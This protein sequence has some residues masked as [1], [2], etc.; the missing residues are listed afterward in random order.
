MPVVFQASQRPAPTWLRFLLRNFVVYNPMFVFSALLALVGAFLINPPGADGGRE[1]LPQAQ[2]FGVIQ[3]YECA[4]L[5]AAWLLR[6]RVPQADVHPFAPETRDVRFL[7]IVLAPFLLDV[8]FTTSSL[9]LSLLTDFGPSRAFVFG[10]ALAGFAC[11]KLHLALRLVGIR[12]GV[13][14][15][16]VFVLGPAAV[17]ATPLVGGALA[18]EGHVDWVGPVLGAVAAALVVAYGAVAGAEGSAWVMRRLAPLALVAALVH[19]C[20]A[21]YTYDGELQLVLGP[22]LIAL[23]FALPRLAPLG[24]WAV[25][26]RLALPWT[27]AVLCG[28]PVGHDHG[29]TGWTLGLASVLV[30]HGAFFGRTR[31]L[32]YLVGAL[33]AVYLGSAGADLETSLAGLGTRPIEPLLLGALILAAGW[34]G[35]AA[36]LLVWPLLLTAALSARL[37]LWGTGLD[38]VLGFNVVGV[39]LLLWAFRDYGRGVEGAFPRAWAVLFLVIPAGVAVLADEPGALAYGGVLIGA[40]GVV[41]LLSRL[42]VFGLPLLLVP[43]ELASGAAPS[44]ALGWGVLGLITAFCGLAAGVAVSCN[45]EQLLA[46][47][48]EPPA[49][50]SPP[51]G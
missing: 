44:T 37:D 28:L 22:A 43:V 21:A 35:V 10:A 3:L 15:R 26:A 51:V 13:F 30:V 25:P 1:L 29:A 18:Q 41:G 27:G 38:A 19:G 48:D 33:A 42:P 36:E 2:L 12:F 49:P 5:G 11:L 6:R 24:V 34:R 8:T 16:L 17:I 46:W 39:G 32:K 20:A 7:V 45:R 50:S 14:E 23:G 9:G 47:L 40:L 31:E 4:L